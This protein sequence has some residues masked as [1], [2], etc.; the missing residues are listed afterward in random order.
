MNISSFINNLFAKYILKE[1]E[2]G[3]KRHLS[4]PTLKAWSRWSGRKGIN[5]RSKH[6]RVI[7]HRDVNKFKFQCTKRITVHNIMKSATQPAFCSTRHTWL[8][9]QVNQWNVKDLQLDCPPAS[10]SPCTLQG[11][12]PSQP[13]ADKGTALSQPRLPCHFST[14]PAIRSISVTHCFCQSLPAARVIGLY[15]GAVVATRQDSLNR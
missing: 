1:Q 10:L 11:W 13:S 2:W 5:V 15:T 12:R 8:L 3:K 4:V 6:S 9:F 7:R 14:K